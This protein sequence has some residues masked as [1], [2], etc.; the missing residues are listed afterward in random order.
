VKPRGHFYREAPPI[1][2]NPQLYFCPD[3]SG[4][5][6]AQTKVP[7]SGIW[8]VVLRR[9]RKCPKILKNSRFHK[10]LTK[11]HRK[12]MGIPISLEQKFDRRIG[13]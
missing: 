3:R 6:G 12:A 8:G 9:L 1:S 7:P 5:F 13:I 2:E 10:K 11:K 4:F